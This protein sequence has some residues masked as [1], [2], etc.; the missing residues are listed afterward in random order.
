MIRYSYTD[1][2]SF[3][4][5]EWTRGHTEINEFTK[6]LNKTDSALFQTFIGYS[7]VA[8]LKVT[9]EQ[10]FKRWQTASKPL[11][12][13]LITYEISG[14][15]R[16]FKELQTYRF[17]KGKYKKIRSQPAL[18]WEVNRAKANNASEDAS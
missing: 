13:F 6:L 3:L 18:P 2:L 10:I 1:T 4:E 11:I 12:A 16:R 5:W 14:R 8:D 17:A 9:I 15:K 7:R